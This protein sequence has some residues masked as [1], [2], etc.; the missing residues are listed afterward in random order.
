MSDF[1]PFLDTAKV[2]IDFSLAGRPASICLHFHKSGATAS[3]YEDLADHVAGNI[4]ATFVADFTD[5]LTYEEVT[6]YDQT[7]ET[8]PKY[9]STSGLPQTGGAAADTIP[10]QNAWVVTYETNR[11]G[12]SYRGRSYMPGLTDAQVVDSLILGATLTNFLAKWEAV[13]INIEVDSGWTL[14]VASRQ[15][16][17]VLRTLGVTTPVE[18]LVAR[19]VVRS[20]RRRTRAS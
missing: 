12:R 19:N 3:D 18:V 15:E 7:S 1:V 9:V 17:G 14:V 13:L 2:C 6:V 5:D 10:T 20:Q 8:A 4:D 16:N 11:R